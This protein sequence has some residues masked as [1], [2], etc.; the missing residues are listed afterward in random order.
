MLGNLDD[1][2]CQCGVVR[3]LRPCLATMHARL[4]DCKSAHVNAIKRQQR[5]PRWETACETAMDVLEYFAQ[6]KRLRQLDVSA[7]RPIVKIASDN[8]RSMRRNQPLDARTQRVQLTAAMAGK[9][10]E[11][12]AH[13]M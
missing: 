2:R 12:N 5:Q 13:A 1:G 4:P 9:Q 10:T 3:N 6:P 11:M 8:Q 7:P